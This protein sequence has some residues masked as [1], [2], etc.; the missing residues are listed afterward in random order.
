MS[1]ITGAIDDV[2]AFIDQNL[3]DTLRLRII[4][5]EIPILNCDPIEIR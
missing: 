2:K 4:N 3:R 1:E 5:D